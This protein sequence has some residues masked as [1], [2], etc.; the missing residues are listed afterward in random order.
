MQ[1]F[2]SVYEDR[3]RKTILY[4]TSPIPVPIAFGYKTKADNSLRSWLDV[5]AEWTAGGSARFCKP[6]IHSQNACSE[7]D[8]ACSPW[9][10]P[11][12]CLHV[13]PSCQRQR[14]GDGR[15][16]PAHPFPAAAVPRDCAEPKVLWL[17]IIVQ[18]LEWL[19][20]G[21]RDTV[22]KQPPGIRPQGLE[23]LPAAH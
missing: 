23:N 5:R 19:R 8:R 4:A 9:P 13:S 15:S 17:H 3:P 6:G 11:R 18:G 12:V 7:K 10:D 16:D 2:L 1:I 14:P 21:S 22:G 20:V